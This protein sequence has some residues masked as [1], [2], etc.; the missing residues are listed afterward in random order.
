MVAVTLA[1]MTLTQFIPMY[2]G[3]YTDPQG[4]KGIYRV[5]LDLTKGSFTVPELAAETTAPSYVAVR[6]GGKSLYAVNEYSEGEA[7]A[8]AIE[9]TGLRKLNTVKFDGRGP[10]HISM[11][12]GGRWLF[13]SAY[14]GGTMS[15][16]PIKADGSIGEAT[17][18]FKNQGMGPNKGRQ[19][20]PHMH[21]AAPFGKFAYACDLGTDEVLVFGLNEETGKLAFVTPRAGKPEPGSGPRH[22][23]IHPN[24]KTLYANNEMTLG[25]SVFDRN[26]DSGQL[27]LVQTISTLPYGEPI[28]GKSTAAIRIH[29]TLPVLYVS[30]RGHNSIAIFGIEPD[31]K[32]K[33]KVVHM[34]PVKEPR[35]FAIDPSGTWLVAAGQNSG[36]LMSLR[37][38]QATGELDPTIYRAKVPKP[39]C[40]AFAL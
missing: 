9:P 30:N 12:A 7:S 31:G 19:E 6:P 36:E 10:C 37:I 38:D 1:A 2:I 32:L 3:T 26:L 13:I 25:V 24:G 15:I 18:N 23:V 33:L 22:F 34:L 16:L 8:F 29:P 28:K 40:V 21:F 17:E 11:D 14:G 4:S 35:D 20:A 27:S 5:E 39:V